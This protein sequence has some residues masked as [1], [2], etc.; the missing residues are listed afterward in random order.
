MTKVYFKFFARNLLTFLIPMLVPLLVLGTLS[1]FLISQYI[2]KEINNNNMNLLKQTKGN[3]ELIFN[4]LDTLNLHIVASALQFTNL[5]NMMTKEFPEPVDYDQLASLKNFIDSPSI[6]KPYID[7]IYIY[8]NNDRKRF[9][10]STTGGLVE[11]NDFYDSDWYSSYQSHP[12]DELMWAESRP[13]IRPTTGQST[14]QTNV[15]TMFRRISVAADNDGII[16]LN[17]KPDYITQSL[18]ELDT[19]QGQSIFILDRDNNVIFR[20][21]PDYK[22]T[23]EDAETIYRTDSSFFSMKINGETQVLNKL[24]SAKYQWTFLSSVPSDSLYVIPNGLKLTTL[25]LLIISFAIGTMLA[26]WL[27]RKNYSNLKAIV[28]ILDFAKSGRPLPPLPRYSKDVFGYILQNTLNHF[29]EHNFLKVQLSE[30][31]YLLQ[32]LEF[33]ALHAQINPHFLFNTLETLNWKASKLTGGPNDMTDIIENLSDILRYS[34]EGG[35]GMV[36]LQT[37]I[38]QTLPYIAILRTRYKDKFDV[39]WDVDDK[40]LKYHVLKLTF[41]PLIE[42]SLYHGIKEKDSFGQIRV[43]ARVSGARLLLSVVDNG[44]GVTAERLAYLRTQLESSLEQ[45]QHIGMFNTQKRLKLTYGKPFGLTIRSKLGWG[46]GI[47]IAIPI[48]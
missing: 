47:Y 39:S 21:H 45:S 44:I 7:S 18:N 37:E 27:T 30:R 9:I 16:V 15:I 4:E 36:S 8:L 1:T 5:K 6:G 14:V 31:K 24:A 32:T 34:L 19:L 42:N 41:Q 10:S 11:L 3:I 29:I 46:T 25:V 17:V 40:A 28:T 48:D 35:S 23:A 13:V 26:Y 33:E 20:N 12:L 22:L 43:K 2:T 38:N